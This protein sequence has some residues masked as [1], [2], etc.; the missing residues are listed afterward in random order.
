MVTGEFRW[1]PLSSVSPSKATATIRSFP[2]W[3]GD[4]LE[5][6]PQ[7]ILAK[8]SVLR[9][10]K[11]GHG[12]IQELPT[13]ASQL[14]DDSVDILVAVVDTD[15]TQIGERRRLLQEAKRRCANWDWRFA[16]PTGW[17][18]IHSKR[19]CWRTKRAAF[20]V[21][22]GDRSNV[23]FP[24]PNKISRPRLLSTGSCGR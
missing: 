20:A 12:F 19:G 2:A 7:I 8:N 3:H 4:D 16:S 24:S 14:R 1:Q 21:F 22:D 11:R 6:A 5:Y 15:N 17:L 10:R 23:L 18:Y 13:F 9:P